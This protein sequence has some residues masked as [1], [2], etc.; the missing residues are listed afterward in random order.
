[1]AFKFLGAPYPI[2]STPKGYLPVSSGLS[3]LKADLLQLLLT[4]PGER[5]FTGD[6]LIPLAIGIEKPIQELVG[7]EPFWIYSYDSTTNAIVPGK[8][9]AHKT[10]TNANLIEITLDNNEKVRC[11]LNHLWLLRDGS[12]KRA[13]ELTIGQSLMPLYRSKNTS[14]Y[15]RVYQPHL[16]DSKETHRCFV[17]GARKTG[18]REVVHHKDLNKL[19][20]SPDNL[21]WM[22][23]EAHRLLHQEIRSMFDKKIKEDPNFKHDWLMK[24][25]SGL[26][27]YYK[28]HSGNRK[29][30][31]LSEETKK[32]SSDQ[33]KAYYASPEGI[34]AK[35]KLRKA[36][37]KQFIDGHPS[38]G[39]THSESSKKKMSKPRPSMCGDS[40][41]AKRPEVKE[42]LKLAWQKRRLKN[43]KVIDMQL[44]DYKEDCYDLH[45]DKYH[46][47][48]ISAGVF[49]H[50]C[51]LPG[52][53]TALRDLVY[54]PNDMILE[55]RAR[56]MIIGSIVRWE[57]RVAVDAI[58]ITSNV[59]GDIL[60][61]DDGL[62][63]RDKVLGIRIVFKDP[64]NLNT[65]QELVLEVPL[66]Q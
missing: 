32:K 43:H 27:D 50:N 22:T 12:Y 11:T 18:E 56:E 36:A 3:T 14:G 29:G 9:T 42:K 66:Q 35:D 51:M 13:D 60:A 21:Q 6:T 4:Y 1:M 53:G 7:V 44:L 65:I 34:L 19:N 39:K 24:M 64:Q 52:F 28:S 8:A 37:K 57:P 47:F 40:N 46:N 62:T 2:Q 5:C 25:K 58:E 33:K 54:E 48:A 10:I 41:P 23:C 16:S 63:E 15:E 61:S 49:V 17:E 59:D 45:V 38:T 26:S 30:A 31:V 55:E 20:N